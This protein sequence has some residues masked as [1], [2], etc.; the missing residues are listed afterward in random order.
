MARSALH[1]GW[2]VI[3]FPEGAYTGEQ[4]V[5]KGR[6][7]AIR[8]LFEA[9][10]QGTEAQFL[11]IGIDT[12]ADKDSLDELIS[13]KP[14]RITIGEPIDYESLYREYSS[15]EDD[16]SRK[17]VFRTMTDIAMRTIAELSHRPYKDEFIPLR[18]RST[19]ILES[20][21]E[22]PIKKEEDTS[23]INSAQRS[24]L[25]LILST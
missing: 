18:P 15:A 23:R 25:P 4:E 16:A 22:V 7:G 14:I 17:Q 13:T 10:D 20:G 8:L 5:T 12:V 24:V 21:E 9:K 6:T 11:P 3:A 1:E 2:P 19:I